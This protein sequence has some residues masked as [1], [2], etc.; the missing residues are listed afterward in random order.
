MS[1]TELIALEKD[2]VNFNA[3]ELKTL[4]ENAKRNIAAA[5]TAKD[6]KKEIC[7]LWKKIDKFIRPLENMPGIGKFIKAFAEILDAICLYIEGLKMAAIV[8][9]F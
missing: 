3:D 6:V 1:K 4:T 7:G 8:C 5:Q 9:H 2:M